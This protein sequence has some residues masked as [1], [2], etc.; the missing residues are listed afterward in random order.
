VSSDDGLEISGGPRA[1]LSDTLSYHSL[2]H[3]SRLEASFDS[4]EGILCGRFV[5][6]TRTA[7]SSLQ[8]YSYWG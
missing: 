1:H 6:P 8:D 2:Y 5:P 4:R 3:Q 7:W